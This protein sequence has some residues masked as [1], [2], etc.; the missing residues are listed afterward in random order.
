MKSRCKK[1]IINIA[2]PERTMLRTNKLGLKYVRSSTNDIEPQL[3][4]PKRE[5]VLPKCA[6]IRRAVGNPELARL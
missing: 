1:S 3:A 6:N 2:M 5:N 4:I